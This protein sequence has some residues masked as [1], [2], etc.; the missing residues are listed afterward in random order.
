MTIALGVCAIPVCPQQTSLTPTAGCLKTLIGERPY[1][2]MNITKA[3]G[4]TEVQKQS[5][6]ALGAVDDGG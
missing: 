3:Q 6:L 5:L 2:G 1:E 4:L